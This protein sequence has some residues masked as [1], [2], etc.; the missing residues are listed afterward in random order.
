[1]IRAMRNKFF[2]IGVSWFWA[3]LLMLA[4]LS[5]TPVRAADDVTPSHAAG[6][7][8]LQVTRG[9]DALLLSAQLN[10][11][12]PSTV[13]EALAWGVPVYFIAEADIVHPRWYWTDRRLGQARRYWRLSYLPLTRRWRLANSPEPL[14]EEGVGTGLAQHY[15][16]LDDA[17]AALQHITGWRIVDAGALE[18][19]GQQTLI[20]SFHLDTPRLPRTLQIGLSGQHD[21]RLRIE[22]RIDLT[23]DA[24]P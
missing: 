16:S 2:V 19:G 22:Q 1:M 14:S 10:F 17:M 23:Q 12:L 13:R 7:T 24:A 21:W 11:A 4:L 6:L 3:A 5:G 15:D 9:N 8:S 18:R 20:F